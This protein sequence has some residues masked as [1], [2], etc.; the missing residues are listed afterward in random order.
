MNAV[1]VILFA[2][3]RPYH[4]LKTLAALKQN[5]LSEKS[6]L[7]IYCDGPKENASS[8]NLKAIDNVRRIVRLDKWCR[9]INI[10]ESQSNKGL[11]ESIIEGVTE[12]INKFGRVIVL[13]DDMVTSKYF[14]RYMNEALDKYE[15]EKGVMSVSGYMYPIKD[16]V[17]D[18]FFI[19]YADCW[20]WGTWK[21]GWEVL[22]NDSGD[23]LN[24]I[25]EKKLSYEFDFDGTFHYT[26]MLEQQAEGKIDSWAIRWYAS[27]FLK[28]GLALLPGRSLVKNIGLDATGTHGDNTSNLDAAVSATPVLLSDIP[29]REDDKNRKAIA[30]FFRSL[31]PPQPF[32]QKGTNI[33]RTLLRKSGI[34][35]VIKTGL[36]KVIPLSPSKLRDQSVIESKKYGW[37]GNYS[38]WQEAQ[39]LCSGYDAQNILEKVKVSTLKVKN[40]EAVYERDSVLFDTIQY[41]QNVLNALFT[42]AEKNKNELHVVDFGGSLGSSYFQYRDFLSRLKELKWSVVEQPHFVECGKNFIQDEHLKFFYSITEAISGKK[43]HVF[44]LSSVLPYFEKP[45]QLIEEC[46]NYGFDYIIVDRTSFIEG[47]T[48]RLTVQVVPE[49]IYKASYPCWFLNERKFVQ[50]FSSKYHLIDEFDSIFDPKEMLDDKWTY[51]KGFIFE[52]K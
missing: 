24:Q 36:K 44:F 20:G 14:L 51:R 37:S 7:F 5:E 4:T 12:I 23:L 2:Y 30:S 45:Y 27:V 19:K 21:R 48:E 33:L 47:E 26:K 25:R 35:S 15:N 31:N 43:N 16:K 34:L 40:G 46:L 10:I 42:A 28:N 49:F 9:K 6:E 38:S 11:A 17:P 18:T 50:S 39:K 29:V 13:E 41:S 32:I 8:E 22:N 1:P 3:N 52:R